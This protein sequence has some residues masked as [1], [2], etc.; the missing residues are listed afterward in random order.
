MNRVCSA[1]LR[2]RQGPVCHVLGVT[3]VIAGCNITWH[4]LLAREVSRAPS[5]VKQA[6]ILRRTKPGAS[7]ATND[8]LLMRP[9]AHAL[10]PSKPSSRYE[11]GSEWTATLL[12]APPAPRPHPARLHAQP[13]PHSAGRVQGRAHVQVHRD[14]RARHWC[15]IVEVYHIPARACRHI[16][17]VCRLRHVQ[18]CLPKRTCHPPATCGPVIPCLIHGAVDAPH[19]GV[20]G[21]ATAV[22]QRPVNTRCVATPLHE[23]C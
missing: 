1:G 14:R 3:Q 6:V 21:H 19:G 16:A 2:G 10:H 5:L 22:L 8:Q 15:R 23:R 7:I 20:L 4:A 18:H 17:A 11:I 12:L 13:V 9:E